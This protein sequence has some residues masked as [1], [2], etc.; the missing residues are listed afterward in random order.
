[1]SL[2]KI[3][4]CDCSGFCPYNAEYFSSC[5]YWCGADETYDCEYWESEEEEDDDC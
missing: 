1:M 2:R 4:P 3:T 5:E